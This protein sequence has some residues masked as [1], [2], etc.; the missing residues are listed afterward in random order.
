M[1][2]PFVQAVYKSLGLRK[3]SQHPKKS[4]SFSK[5]YHFFIKLY[6]ISTNTVYLIYTDV[7]NTS[8][9]TKKCNI[10]NLGNFS[11]D[12]PLDKQPLLRQ[13]LHQ[14][15]GVLSFQQ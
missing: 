7:G 4:D 9:K 5:T 8:F 10:E 11:L 14:L 15:D 13:E 3:R 6:Y 12:K 2:S 1:M